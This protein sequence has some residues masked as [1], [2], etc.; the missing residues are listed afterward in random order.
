[1]LVPRQLGGE[2]FKYVL[3]PCAKKN[4]TTLS[5]SRFDLKKVGEH[6]SFM[7]Q[8]VVNLATCWEPLHSFD[9][10]LILTLSG[11][12]GCPWVV[13]SS[14]CILSVDSMLIA[15]DDRKAL[16]WF[17]SN[18]GAISSAFIHAYITVDTTYP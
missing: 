10:H 3:I 5:V 15:A 18:S 16:V 4:T 8:Y 14:L 7:T 12:L 9:V 13:S 2:H 11:F 6:Q 1:M 17:L